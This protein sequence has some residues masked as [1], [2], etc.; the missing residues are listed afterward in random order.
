M[1][2]A[3]CTLGLLARNPVQ[4]IATKM[5]GSTGSDRQ[6]CL[7]DLQKNPAQGDKSPLLPCSPAPLRP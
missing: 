4:E 7:G 2:Y 1:H 3:Y 5:T 6:T